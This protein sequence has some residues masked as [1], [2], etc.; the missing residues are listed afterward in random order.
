MRNETLKVS[1]LSSG[2]TDTVEA[3]QFSLRTGKRLVS[4]SRDQTVCVWDVS[5]LLNP[6]VRRCQLLYTLRG[7]TD[8]VYTCA[9][10]P[11]E[12]LIARGSLDRTVRLWDVSEQGKGRLLHTLTGIPTGFV[13][14]PL[15]PT[16]CH[17]SAAAMIIR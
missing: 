1:S 9:F 16:A 3:I 14:S 11:D 4:A 17:W 13:V 10:S 6:D 12:R 7:H 5:S 8:R 2:H 15:A